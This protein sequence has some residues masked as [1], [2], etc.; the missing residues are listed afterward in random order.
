MR[1]YEK[2]QFDRLLKSQQKYQMATLLLLEVCKRN[3][4]DMRWVW[5]ADKGTIAEEFLRIMTEK[6]C[7]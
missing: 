5:E 3:A 7:E 4:I 1:D 6:I 2:E